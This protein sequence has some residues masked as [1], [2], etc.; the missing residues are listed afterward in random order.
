M[1]VYVV[2]HPSVDE[3]AEMI[4]SKTT[5]TL[6]GVM[7][8]VAAYLIK[9]GV[10]GKIPRMLIGMHIQAHGNQYGFDITGVNI[11]EGNLI[12][13]IVAKSTSSI[14]DLYIEEKKDLPDG[15]VVVIPQNQHPGRVVTALKKIGFEVTEIP[16]N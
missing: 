10:K 12:P 2:N 15:S 14:F 13:E 6:L 8:D 3:F 4:G 9:K 16:F 11:R 7:S 1:K 5:R